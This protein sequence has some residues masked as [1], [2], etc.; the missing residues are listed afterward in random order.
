ME[1]V[2]HWGLIAA[3][4]HI[5]LVAAFSVA[6]LANLDLQFIAQLLL[7]ALDAFSHRCRR[8]TL[9]A[10]HPHAYSATRRTCRHVQ[11]RRFDPY[12]EM[13]Q[14]MPGRDAIV[15]VLLR[16]VNPEF[17]V[18]SGPLTLV[19]DG[20]AY[21]PLPGT[22]TLQHFEQRDQRR[23]GDPHDPHAHRK[24]RKR[25]YRMVIQPADGRS[26]RFGEV[27]CD[28]DN[29]LCLYAGKVGEDLTQMRAVGALQLHRDANRLRQPLNVCSQPRREV[30]RF[31]APHLAQGHV[32][33]LAKLQV[34]LSESQ[35]E[36]L[37]AS[38]GR[39]YNRW[40][41]R[42]GNKDGLSERHACT[43]G[44]GARV[45]PLNRL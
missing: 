32:L 41:A 29:G 2:G 13:G 35:S 43:A 30:V 3:I 15:R 18:E 23:I 20:R 27:P 40:K 9:S 8:L 45:P 5:D 38:L 21:A 6:A 1:P 7:L 25:F 36:S 26:V 4:S 33:Q 44:L 24:E 12:V 16:I 22:G 10:T 34:G 31:I 39:E 37:R 42:A 17:P 14:L 11:L 19:F 28:P